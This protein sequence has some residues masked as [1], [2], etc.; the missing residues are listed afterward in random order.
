MTQISR[1]RD[2]SIVELIPALRAFARTFYSS[3]SDADDLVQDTL[4]KALNAFD[5]FEPGTRLKSWLFTI[6]RNTF[7]TKIKLYTREAPAAADCAAA[8]PTIEAAQEWSLRAIEVRD[9]LARLPPHQREVLT[10]IGVLGQSYEDTAA[11]CG[12]AVGTVK[13]RLNRARLSILEDLGEPSSRTLTEPNDAM[14]SGQVMSNA[15]KPH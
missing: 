3:P 11:I 10:L 5:S 9:A 15:S 4:V 14:R 1:I 8:L 13:S 6:M 2:D 7:Y 12:C